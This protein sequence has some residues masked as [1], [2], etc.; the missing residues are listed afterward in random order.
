M[1]QENV[2]LEEY[3]RGKYIFDEFCVTLGDFH[4]LYLE[5]DVLHLACFFEKF[6]DICLEFYSLDPATLLHYTFL[7]YFSLPGIAWD[8]AL[9]KSKIKLDQI[10]D[11]EMHNMIEASLRGGVSMICKRESIANNPYMSEYQNTERD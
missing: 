7:H 6:R 1:S 5:S 9:L 2:T 10:V 8:A 3:N 11:M 4:D